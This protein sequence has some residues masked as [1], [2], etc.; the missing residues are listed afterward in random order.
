MFIDDTSLLIKQSLE[1]LTW[2]WKPIHSVYDY[3]TLEEDWFPYISF[4]LWSIESNIVSSCWVERDVI[5]ELFIVQEVNN[6]KRRDILPYVYIAIES[7]LD[8][9]DWLKIPWAFRTR[10]ASWWLSQVTSDK[11]NVLLAS[12]TFTVTYQPWT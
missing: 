2:A 9:L 4:E 10:S 6:V 11:W 12:I 3:Y 1:E 5:F 7:C 8:K